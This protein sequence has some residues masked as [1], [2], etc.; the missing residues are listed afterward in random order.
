MLLPTLGWGGKKFWAVLSRLCLE[1]SASAGLQI[2]VPSACVSSPKAP[3]CRN[4]LLWFLRKVSAG[5][6]R[7]EGGLRMTCS[8]RRR[9]CPAQGWPTNQDVMY[10]CLLLRDRVAWRD[11]GTTVSSYLPLT[12]L[13]A[14]WG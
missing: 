8:L 4:F 12:R 13:V 9:P 11:E 10:I 14:A 2:L 1:P 6:G 3:G 5:V 7:E